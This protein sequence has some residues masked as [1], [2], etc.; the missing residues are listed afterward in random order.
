MSGSTV[1][2]KRFINE[3]E[4]FPVCNSKIDEAEAIFSSF[5]LF[6]HNCLI[7][8]NYNLKWIRLVEKD[9]RVARR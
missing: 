2:Y 8:F 7:Q 5:F 9:I 1:K 4:D 6:F 3:D